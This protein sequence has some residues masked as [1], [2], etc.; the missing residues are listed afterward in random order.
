LIFF[1]SISN[2]FAIDNETL[3]KQIFFQLLDNV[4]TMTAD[5]TQ[6]TD[7]KDVGEDIYLGKMYLISKKKVLWDY[8][9]PYV[10]YYIF[11]PT[12]MDYYDSTTEQLIKKRVNQSGGDNIIFNLLVDFSS[13]KNEFNI[14]FIDNVTIKMIPKDDIGLKYLKVKFGQKFIEE[15][16]SIDDSG[17]STRV[18]LKNIILNHHIDENIFEK[19]VPPDTEIFEE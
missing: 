10:Q 3:K 7:I 9:K 13:A 18:Y 1:I 15:I 8:Y 11:T 2:T 17:N 6:I 12:S 16:E 14:N 4:T 19:Q 5:F